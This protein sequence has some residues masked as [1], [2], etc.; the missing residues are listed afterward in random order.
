[1][2]CLINPWSVALFANIF[3]QSV[4]FSGWTWEQTF[5]AGGTACTKAQNQVISGSYQVYHA[6]G[7]KQLE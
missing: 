3:S 6:L 2:S 5:Q 7:T 1:M 4:G